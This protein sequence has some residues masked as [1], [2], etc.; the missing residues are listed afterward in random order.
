[1]I[2]DLLTHRCRVVRSVTVDRDGSPVKTW[3]TIAE[4]VPC[5]FSVS[6]LDVDPLWDLTITE[7][8]AV[9]G[10]LIASPSA[11]I[12]PNDRLV[13]TRP[14]GMGTARVSARGAVVPGPHGPSHV[15]YDVLW[16]ER[17]T[18]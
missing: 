13:F 5:L 9:M 14:V 15:S 10:K 2:N 7:R 17:V 4:D 18:A 1:M 3:A 12:K 6:T 16:S 11:P 8:A